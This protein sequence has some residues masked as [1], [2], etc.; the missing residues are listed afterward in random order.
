M[1]SWEAQNSTCL[2]SRIYKRL[3]SVWG[4]GGRFEN[5]CIVFEAEAAAAAAGSNK[6]KILILEI[7]C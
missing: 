2:V 6:Y 1:G 7:K 5:R 3:H 4:S